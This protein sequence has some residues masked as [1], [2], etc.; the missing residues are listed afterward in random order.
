MEMKNLARDKAPVWERNVAK[1]GGNLGAFAFQV[2]AVESMNWFLN[3]SLNATTTFM[4]TVHKA[5]KFGWNRVDDSYDARIGT[6]QC[7]ENAGAL[8]NHHQIHPQLI[9]TTYPR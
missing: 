6:L 1:Y 3:P 2:D 5:R 8:P 4:C 9:S 7:Y